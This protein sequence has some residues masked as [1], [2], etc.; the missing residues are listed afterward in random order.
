MRSTKLRKETKK[1]ENKGWETDLTRDAGKGH[2]QV[3]DGQPLLQP[4]WKSTGQDQ[5]QRWGFQKGGPQ[6]LRKHQCLMI[7]EKSSGKKYA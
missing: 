6:E 2:F 3:D 1:E 4:A 7:L 5:N